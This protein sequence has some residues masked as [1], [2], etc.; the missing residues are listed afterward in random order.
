MGGIRKAQADQAIS[1]AMAEQIRGSRFKQLLQHPTTAWAILFCSVVITIIA[2][3]VSER[4]VIARAADRFHFQVEDIKASIE[5]RMRAQERVLLG[6]VGLFAASKSVERDGWKNYVGALQLA[7]NYPGLQGLG[8][9]LVIPPKQKNALQRQIRAEG[10]PEFEIKPP[11]ERDIY[12]SI[13]YLEPF[14]WRN[15]RAFGFDM[16]SEPTRRAAME[17]ARDSGEAAMSAKVTLVQETKSDV[18]NGFLMYLPVYR[19]GMPVST[20]EQRRA[21]LLGYVYSPFRIK[22]LMQ[23]IL[24]ARD[25]DV[26]M[27]IFDGDRLLAENLLYDSNDTLHSDDVRHKPDFSVTEKVVFAGHTWSLYLSSRPGYI[28]ISEES[29]PLIV[30]AGGGLIDVLLF[31][32]ISSISRQHRLAIGLINDMSVMAANSSARVQA[33]VN[34]V[35]DGIITINAVGT[36]ETVN[37]AVVATFGYSAAELVGQNVKILMPE[38]D[39]TRHDQYLRSYHDTGV[40]KI[41]GTP[42]Q[43]FGRRRDGSVFPLEL[44]VG[45]LTRDDK[46]LYVGILRDVTERHESSQKMKSIIHELEQRAREMAFLSSLGDI[47]QTCQN[48]DEAYKVVCGILPKMFCH[49]SG[50]L[51]VTSEKSR[52][53]EMACHWGG[54]LHSQ[55][56]ESHECMAVRR[57]M[58]FLNDSAQA[59]LHCKH[60]ESHQPAMS[61]CVPL[62]AQGATIGML[63]LFRQEPIADGA[64][65]A[66]ATLTPQKQE[67][68]IAASKQIA[69]AL[70][71]LTLRQSLEQRSI[72]DALT[73][74]NNRHFI[75]EMLPREIQRVMRL[76]TPS[77]AVLL[78]DVD[79]F[80]KINDTYGHAAGDR[81]LREIARV[82]GVNTRREDLVCRYGGEEF[83]VVLAGANISG[84][85]DRASRLRNEVKKLRIESDGV[86]LPAVTISIGIAMLPQQGTDEDSLLRQAD[87]ALYAAKAAGR[88]QVMVAGVENVADVAGESAS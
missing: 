66:E 70:A 37:P 6:G 50:A 1:D 88:D 71:N 47:L 72:H 82:L 12:T 42:R 7:K 68:V 64:S 83:V 40:A 51:Y 16:F 43:V 28:A 81:V 30:A 9:S 11:G 4:F 26:D 29:Q 38:P 76:E 33:I 77:L 18:Q 2:W 39:H 17:R 55:Q 73:G 62:I 25:S 84:A 60:F 75:Q 3:Y 44:A 85:I 8:F 22:D 63:T 87:Q 14:D 36:I 54:A 48:L 80:K 5:K 41:I 61:Y 78:L 79:H 15:Q 35:V 67:L 24:G 53:M 59:V 23:G 10:F 74:L 57:G 65:D 86:R 45:A 34:N 27:E 46:P 56:I 69:M 21:A 13:I 49:Y 52:Q 20:I 58:P 31:L 32:I 19:N